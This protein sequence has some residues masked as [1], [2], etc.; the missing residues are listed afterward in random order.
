[1]TDHIPLRQF[2]LSRPIRALA[3]DD[4]QRIDL[5]VFTGGITFK[6][7]GPVTRSGAATGDAI[8]NLTYVLQAGDTD[9]VGEY[10]A[11]FRGVDGSGKPQTFPQGTNLRITVVK[12]L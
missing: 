5:T 8:G 2:D 7:V 4:A 1:M 6:M 12:A 9:V 3:F 11:T 10:V